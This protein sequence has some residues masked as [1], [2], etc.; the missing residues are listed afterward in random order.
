M[1]RA[2]VVA[3][4][5]LAA[6]ATVAEARRAAP[7]PAE[8]LGKA[9]AAY[10]RGDL[11]E[12]AKQLRGL[13]S[14]QLVNPDYLLWIR[15]QIAL[16]EGRPADAAADFRALAKVKGTRFAVDAAWRLADCQ[17]EQG[18]RAGAA[19]SYKKLADADGASDHGDLGVAAFRIATV[20]RGAARKNAL[21][22]FL[23]RYPAHPHAAEAEQL[24]VADGG[25]TAAA[26]DAGERIERAQRL[27]SAHLWH[28]AVAE[29]MLIADTE[30]EATRTRR[31]YWLGTS[32]YKMRR[33]YGDAGRLL[34]AVAPKMDSA[35]ALFHGAR[36]LSRADH[37]DEAIRWYREV[38]AK[39]PR[40]DWAAEAQYL[41][42]WLEFNRGR[43]KEA[44]APLEEMLR[45]YPSSKWMDDALWFLGMS[46]FLLGDDAGALPHLE[47]LSK[48]G[49]SLEGGKGLYWW[50]RTV[51]RLGRTDEAAAAYERI[52]GRWPFAWYALLAQARLKEMGR[53]LASP[54]GKEPP[55]PRGPTV[56]DKLDPKVEA[57]PAIAKFDELE[58]A[59]LDVDAGIELARAEKP[60]VKRHPRAEALAVLFDRYG[61]G[62]NWNRPWK[63]AIAYDGGALDTP[64]EGPA[65]FW[66][67]HAYPE[68]YKD[69]VEEFAPLGKNPPYYLYSIMRKESGYDPHVIS[70]ADAQGLL[71]MIPA[72]TIRVADRLDLDYAPGDLYD[73]RLNVQTGSWYI[74]NLLFKFKGQIPFGAGSFNSGPRPVMRWLEQNG[75]RPV[76]EIVELVSYMQTREYMKKVTENYARYVY[77]YTGKVY[78]QPLAADPAFVVDDLTY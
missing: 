60:F 3:V 4:A 59:G 46:H 66:W 24:L 2:T 71:Q 6:S 74:G 27:I 69:L 5:L 15:G 64:A 55:A 16:V 34:L 65:R 67:Q 56:A 43:Y 49:A 33:R 77:L 52:V 37:D 54:F 26:F 22:E 62:S 58:A 21:R 25:A 38:V 28:E 63:L 31:D 73:P 13:R 42:G 45:R 78:E 51:Q 23:Q 75:A 47:K 18:D 44:I 12:A 70:Y 68:A 19:R 41:T 40:T 29:L 9:Y 53:P 17:W 57:D 32:L 8:R 39:Y 48:R 35:E 11:A 7:P 30:P 14:D 10:E 72:T 50:A 36:A 61:R 1:L 76:D 20:A